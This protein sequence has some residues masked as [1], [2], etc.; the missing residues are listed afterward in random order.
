M[1]SWFEY[2][3]TVVDLPLKIGLCCQTGIFLSIFFIWIFH[4][5][6]FQHAPI[7]P[8]LRV[9]YYFRFNWTFFPYSLGEWEYEYI[10]NNWHTVNLQWQFQ[11]NQNYFAL[12]RFHGNI[13]LNCCARCIFNELIRKKE[14]LIRSNKCFM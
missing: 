7:S 6:T 10:V 5:S 2:G 3:Q 11:N 14:C 9:L 4:S 1:A 8:F 12:N 13:N